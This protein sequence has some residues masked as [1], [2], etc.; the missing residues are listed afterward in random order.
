MGPR[1][2][3]GQLGDPR[4]RLCVPLRLSPPRGSCTLERPDASLG[5]QELSSAALEVAWDTPLRLSHPA[6]GSGPG[7]VPSS[8]HPLPPPQLLNFN[9]TLSEMG[10]SFSHMAPPSR[11]LQT[12]S[13]LRLLL[14]RCPPHPEAAAV[15]K[16]PIRVASDPLRRPGRHPPVTWA[17]GSCEC[18]RPSSGACVLLKGPHRW[19]PGPWSSQGLLW[20]GLE[21]Q[22]P[23]TSAH[24]T[25]GRWP[26]GGS[27][28]CLPGV[29]GVTALHCPL[30]R[31]PC[32]SELI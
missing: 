15:Q 9:P 25:A 23:Q 21:A 12:P 32:K 22:D 19:E 20:A 8:S 26:R 13:P 1:A 7:R 4:G 28:P 11:G 18:P 16:R 5:S 31:C 10:R 6:S 17:P 3:A 2:P 14:L 29:T 30:A 24:Y 27:S